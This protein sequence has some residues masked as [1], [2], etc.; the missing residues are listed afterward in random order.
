MLFVIDAIDTLLPAHDTSVALMETAQLRG[1]RVLITTAE[2]L[3]YDHGAVTAPCTDVVLRPAV[4]HEGS[5]I[6]DPDWYALGPTTEVVLNEVDVV[7][8]RTDPP[9]DDAYLRAT[10]LLDLVDPN[11]TLILNSPRGLRDANEKLFVLQTPSALGTDSQVALTPPTL[12]TSNRTKIRETVLQWGRAVLK[13]T[14]GM[15]GRGVMV[16]DPTDP[17]LG[18]L[19]D[20]ATN[21]GNT[22]VVIQKWIEDVEAEGDRRL[23]VLGGVPIGSVRRRAVEGDFRC[24]MAAGGA[25]EADVVTDRDREVCARLAPMLWS[26]GL[27]LVGLDLIGPYVTEIN[28]TS[29]T[30]IREIDVVGN[31]QAA[32]EVIVWSETQCPRRAGAP[33]N[34]GGSSQ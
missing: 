32:H 24:N 18:T 4:R 21:R 12:V 17:N 26:R 33:T 7:F 13:P 2:Q 20:S 11:R 6:T 10:F 29:P 34:T 31:V 5:W 30:G 16:L 15:A 23:I 27:H 3:G 28:V 8:M 14:D 22:Q 19:L 1:H 9:V 25:P